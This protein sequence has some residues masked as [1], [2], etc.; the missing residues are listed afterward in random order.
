MSR[1]VKATVFRVKLTALPLGFPGGSVVKTRLPMQETQ[2]VWV[3]SLGWGDPLEELETHSNIL[4]WK[5]PWTEAWWAIVRGVSKSQ[6][7]LSA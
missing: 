3:R 2:E 4:A 1:L 7:R 6:T 5:V